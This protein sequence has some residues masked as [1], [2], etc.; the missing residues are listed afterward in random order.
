MGVYSEWSSSVVKAVT[1]L[2]RTKR[3]RVG[4]I[5][6]NHKSYKTIVDEK[7]FTKEYETILD[8]A[9]KLNAQVIQITRKL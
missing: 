2:A 3:M 7:F 5:E 9:T 6:F 8:Q 1:E 4:Y